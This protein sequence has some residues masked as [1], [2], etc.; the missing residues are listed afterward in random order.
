[1]YTNKKLIKIILLAARCLFFVVFR[2]K[3]SPDEEA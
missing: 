3:K 2:E 1:M